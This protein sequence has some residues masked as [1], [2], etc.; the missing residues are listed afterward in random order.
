M[1]LERE[2]QRGCMV[3]LERNLRLGFFMYDP[4]KQK[5]VVFL[6]R[7]KKEKGRTTKVRVTSSGKGTAI[8]A[9]YCKITGTHRKRS[10]ALISDGN[11]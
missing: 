8:T 3:C 2:R 4:P 6:I 10:A 1:L 11:A 7:E 5:P 9:P